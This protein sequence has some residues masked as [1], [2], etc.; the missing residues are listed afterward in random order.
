MKREFQRRSF[1][2][3]NLGIRVL[4]VKAASLKM[5][6]LGMRMCEGEAVFGGG[7]MEKGEWR[8][9]KC[10]LGERRRRWANA[11]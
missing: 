2:H 5:Q 10:M 9:K 1:S 7:I 4:N 3:S 6:A 8:R 11:K